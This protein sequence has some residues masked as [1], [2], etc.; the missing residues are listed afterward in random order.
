MIRITSYNVCYTK[1]LRDEYRKTL[2][3]LRGNRIRMQTQA[4]S[5]EEQLAMLRREIASQEGYY[6]ELDAEAAMEARRLSEAEED[7]SSIDE[8]IASYNFV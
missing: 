3:E 8:E 7:L 2:E 5:A 6:R 1:L 4:Q